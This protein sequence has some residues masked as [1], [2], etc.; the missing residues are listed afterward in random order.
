MDCQVCESK[1][2]NILAKRCVHTNPKVGI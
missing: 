2:K 1:I